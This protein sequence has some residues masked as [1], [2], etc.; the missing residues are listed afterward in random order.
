MKRIPILIIKWLANKLGYKTAM[1]KIGGE[2]PGI[3]IEGDKELLKYVD[4]TG[5]TFNKDPLKR[6]VSKPSE[7][8]PIK[9]LTAEQLKYMNN[10]R[11]NELINEAYENYCKYTSANSSEW[12]EWMRD[13]GDGT[14]SMF[15]K[16]QFITK[17]KTDD[18]FS[19][20]WGLKIEERVVLEQVD[21]NNPVLKGSTSLYSRKLI[22]I[23]YNNETVEIY[24]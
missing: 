15:T 11:F 23:T 14:L 9:S 12:N 2:I 5:Y 3:T 10:E 19:Q 17:C 4:I 22:T 6:V 24:E 8:E 18:E 7:P 13:N 16:N 21:Q 1:I 20:K